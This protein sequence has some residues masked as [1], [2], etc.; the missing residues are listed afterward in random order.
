MGHST[1]RIIS[2]SLKDAYDEKF[3]RQHVNGV[4]GESSAFKGASP[5]TYIENLT[6]PM[7][8]LSDGALTMYSDTFKEALKQNGREDIKFIY[9]EEFNHLELYNDLRFNENSEGSQKNC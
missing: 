8:V 7:L 5:V 3:A 4:F 2:R 9:Y 6:T 1:S